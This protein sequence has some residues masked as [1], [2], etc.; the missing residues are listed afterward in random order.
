MSLILLRTDTLSISQ[1]FQVQKNFEAASQDA[2][3]GMWTCHPLL[4]M[5]DSTLTLRLNA[6]F[7]KRSRIP[8]ISRR[9]VTR[10][11][12]PY[13]S[14]LKWHRKH[15]KSPSTQVSKDPYS[16][17][18]SSRFKI[19]PSLS[20]TVVIQPLDTDRIVHIRNRTYPVCVAVK[21]KLA[22]ETTGRPIQS[23]DFAATG[24][25]KLDASMRAGVQWSNS[26]G[27]SDINEFNTNIDT[28]PMAL[29]TQG[30]DTANYINVKLVPQFTLSLFNRVP[31]YVQPSPSLG[32]EPVVTHNLARKGR[33]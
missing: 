19:L 5:S 1:P 6:E 18:C 4:R 3:N 24:G 32:Y 14:A 30:L 28:Y 11:S 9:T 17:T 21:S 27:W 22:V 20:N 12:I 7:R 25:L 26:N 10:T 33:I 8:R 2:S 31:I 13:L 23:G 15:R 29:L 16:P